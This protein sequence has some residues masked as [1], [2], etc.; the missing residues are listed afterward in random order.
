VTGAGSS[1]DR[2]AQSFLDDTGNSFAAIV[3]P[4][5]SLEGSIFSRPIA[6]RGQVWTAPRMAAGIYNTL[7]FTSAAERGERVY[8][9]WTAS[10][11][12]RDIA[13][14]TVLTINDAGR[15]IGIAIHHRPL[16]AVLAF[17]Q[18]MN[19]RLDGLIEPGHFTE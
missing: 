9:D 12:G 2:W 6:G 3:N 18:E 1:R 5:V 11:L 19:N 16:G 8:L 14:I 10:A 17:S 7:T 4:D 13:G 15:F